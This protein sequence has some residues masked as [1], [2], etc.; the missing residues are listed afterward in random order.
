M[1]STA[2]FNDGKSIA[3]SSANQAFRLAVGIASTR[4]AARPSSRERME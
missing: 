1:R 2:A 4:R 3:T